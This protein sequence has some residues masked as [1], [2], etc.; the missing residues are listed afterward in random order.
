MS[1]SRRS[2]G[3]APMPLK[4]ANVPS[5]CRKKRS[6][7]IMRSMA[8]SSA[9]GGAMLREAK[10]CR[11]GK[12]SSKISMI[13]ADMAAVGKDLPVDLL[14]QPFGRG[15]DVTRLAGDA[16]RGVTERNGRLHAGNATMRVTRGMAQIAHLAD[17]AAQE[18]PVE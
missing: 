3:V 6:I 18:T 9:C 15:F 11:S 7:G 16:Q 13:A 14:F 12:N 1:V 4:C 10:A 5:E 2:A 8:L 17:Q